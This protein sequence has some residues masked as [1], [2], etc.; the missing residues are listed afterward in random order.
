MEAIE[1]LSVLDL[2]EVKRRILRVKLKRNLITLS[3][4]ALLSFIDEWLS[5]ARSAHLLIAA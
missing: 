2:L 3:E 4:M 5:F 1:E